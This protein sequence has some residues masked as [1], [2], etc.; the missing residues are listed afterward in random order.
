MPKCKALDNMLSVKL[1]EQVEFVPCCLFENEPGASFPVNKI[2]FTDFGKNYLN[3]ITTT[4]E[5]SWHKGCRPCQQDEQEGFQSIRKKY[6][7]ML[8][9]KKSSIE[10][11]DIFLSDHCNLACKMCNPSNSNKLKKLV[12]TNPQIQKWYENIKVS[13][14]NYNLTNIFKDIDL[15][16]ITTVNFIGGE[17]F[18]TSDFFDFID[19][20]DKENLIGNITCTVFTNGTFFPHKFLDI[21]KKFKTII[22]LISV[23]GLDDLANYI[24]T[25]FEWET[26]SKN[27]DAW[28]DFKNN[29]KNFYIKIAH[30]LQAYNIHQF[31]SIFQFCR[32]KKL[33]L[34]LYPVNV[35]DY[36]SYKVLP[37]SYRN[38]LIESRQL[39]DQRI[40]DILN[41]VEF[42][43]DLFDKFKEFTYTMDKV[44]N[45]SIEKT[46]PGLFKYFEQHEQKP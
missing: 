16:K 22:I 19:F 13:S 2:N 32:Q 20:L 10:A 21:L 7:S 9:G 34:E 4:M 31:D 30:T 5:H 25:G 6:N 14:N 33:I 42:D 41:K 43:K 46:I 35:K 40:L 44:S 26:I 8:S 17:P 28:L 29:N 45:T 12:D 36:L 27:I 15:T 11:L 1:K 37:I 39:T 23:D 3:N 38:E 24:R 18:I